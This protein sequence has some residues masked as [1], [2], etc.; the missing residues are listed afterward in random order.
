MTGQTTLWTTTGKYLPNAHT[1][2]SDDKK[3]AHTDDICKVKFDPNP[4]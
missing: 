4:V 2:K 1:A 3:K